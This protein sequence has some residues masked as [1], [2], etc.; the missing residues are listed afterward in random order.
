MV[1]QHDPCAG[2]C[3]DLACGWRD[4]YTARVE[5]SCAQTELILAGDPG[6]GHLF[7]LRG[8]RGDQIKMI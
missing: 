7:L 8:R 3:E 4:G 5:W 2:G 1:W 6:S